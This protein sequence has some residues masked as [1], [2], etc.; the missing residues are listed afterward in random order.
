MATG[1]ASSDQNEGTLKIQSHP[2]LYNLGKLKK[3]RRRDLKRG[4]GV[5]M[6]EIYQ[7]LAQVHGR[8]A[9]EGDHHP[10][11]ISYEKKSSKK[12]KNINYMGM[13]INR[14]KMKKR[15]KKYG[16]KY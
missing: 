11:V 1:Q 14:K 5:A 15:M 2:P 9:H 8:V 13:K 16:I 3:R 7:A 10:V 12:K 6:S 4:Q